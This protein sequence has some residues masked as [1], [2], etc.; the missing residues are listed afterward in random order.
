MAWSYFSDLVLHYFHWFAGFL[1]LQSVK[2][3][4]IS[5]LM[6]LKKKKKLSVVRLKY[7]T[8]CSLNSCS[9]VCLRHQNCSPPTRSKPKGLRKQTH[10]FWP[11]SGKCVA[12]KQCLTRT[13]QRM[14]VELCRNSFVVS[15]AL[16]KEFNRH[17]RL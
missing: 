3:V 5:F 17:S 4:F 14:V 15:I 13:A 11:T 7:L 9:R 12:R 6:S 10:C 1:A 2:E 16:H 8:L